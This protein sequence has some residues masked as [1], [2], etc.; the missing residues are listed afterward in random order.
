MQRSWTDIGPF[1]LSRKR[2]N[3]SAAVQARAIAAERRLRAELR[4]SDSV[5]PVLTSEDEDLKKPKIEIERDEKVDEFESEDETEDEDDGQGDAA[6][7]DIEM[8]QQERDWLKREMQD[9]YGDDDIV[10]VDGKKG[11]TAATTAAGATGSESGAGRGASGSSG[12]RVTG[13]GS[14]KTIGAGED[15]HSPKVKKEGGAL[16]TI[17]LDDD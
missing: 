9:L 11:S 17:V 7:D 15:S 8:T 4:A 5:K 10:V 6:A 3:A 2:A 1:R 12:A 16:E 14:S 13:I